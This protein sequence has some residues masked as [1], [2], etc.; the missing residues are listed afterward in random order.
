MTMGAVTSTA[1][2]MWR[3][4]APA[5]A[6]R[7]THSRLTRCPAHPQ[8]TGPQGSAPRAVCCFTFR[9]EGVA[10]HSL[11]IYYLLTTAEAGMRM[12]VGVAPLTQGQANATGGGTEPWEQLPK[13]ALDPL[14]TSDGS[15]GAEQSSPCPPANLRCHTQL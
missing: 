9:W 10:Y 15:T 4:S 14:P 8:V 2:T 5:G 7:G 11:S 6:T 13:W 1:A 3:P 12:R